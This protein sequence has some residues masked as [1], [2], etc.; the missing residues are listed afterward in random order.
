MTREEFIAG[1]CLLNAGHY[2]GKGVFLINNKYLN[3]MDALLENAVEMA[4]KLEKDGI[5][6]WQKDDSN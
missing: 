4:S 6:P 5:A 1:F 3:P 2:V